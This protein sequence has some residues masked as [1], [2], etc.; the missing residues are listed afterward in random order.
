MNRYW[1]SFLGYTL[2]ELLLVMGIFVI[3][4]AMG[5]GGF[6][7]TRETMIARETVENVKQDIQSARLKAMLL[8]K[9]DESNWI[10]GIGIDFNKYINPGDS[11]TV[12]FKWCSPFEDFGNDIT[13]SEILNW[14]SAYDIGYDGIVNPDPQYPEPNPGLTLEPDPDLIID[15]QPIPDVL[16]VADTGAANGYLPLQAVSSC[17]NG[18]TSLIYTTG[19]MISSIL[20]E[21]ENT[22]I[23]SNARYLVF[24]AVTGRAFLYNSEGKPL[25]YSLDGEYI[26]TNL[27]DLEE[28]DIVL[29]RRYSTKFDVITVYPLSGTVI[30][31]V[32]STA[33]RGCPTDGN[34]I[35]I[36]G[37][38]YYRFG[39]AEEINS[40]RE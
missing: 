2:L 22:S 28:L 33:D 26:G 21:P 15:P 6:L 18:K 31:Y 19:D 20:P 27:N 8:K 7:G 32:Y 29:N 17:V 23:I 12:F 34:C 39:I 38:R 9:G 16:G 37:N 1:K 35:I 4:G 13:K 14:D 25:N 10:Y 3:L 5:V 11:K 30:H 36:D 40:Y 24:E